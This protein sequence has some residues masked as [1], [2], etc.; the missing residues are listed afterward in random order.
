MDQE[1]FE[2]AFKS[3]FK[4]KGVK[5]PRG[6][7]SGIS[8][9]LN[10]QTIA[11]L[12]SSQVRYQWVA[13]AA[14]IVAIFSFAI[15]VN[16]SNGNEV[17]NVGGED[18][19]ALLTY[20]SDG[21]DLGITGVRDPF[22][23]TYLNNILFLRENKK[24]ALKSGSMPALIENEIEPEFSELLVLN[25]MKPGINQAAVTTTFNPYYTIHSNTILTKKIVK[26]GSSYWAGVEAGAGSFNPN[27]S[28]ADPINGDVDFAA[29]ASN[30]GQSGFVN[31]TSTASQSGM[32]P[33]VVTSFGVD[34]GVKLG[35][36]WTLESG[37]QYTNVQNQAFAALNVVDVYTIRSGNIFSSD[38]DLSSQLVSSAA[39]ETEV[40]EN[41]EHAVN[42]DHNMKF[43][44]IPVKAG[45][46]L[47][48]ERLSLRFNAG[49]S[50]NY[51]LSSRL[52]DPTGQM[53]NSESNG[54]NEWSFDGL[55]GFELGY[56]IFENFN[57]TLEPNYRQSITPLS[58]SL[59]N[60][61]GF[62]VQTGFRYIIR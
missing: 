27:F 34:F 36:K 13:A 30:I 57:L 32:D 5:P 62:M 25:K 20:N 2:S 7:W 1:S 50:A 18:F 24:I 17:T 3:Q 9:S 33:G 35:R 21:P 45:Y 61:S 22:F 6:V 23:N 29:L 10:D 54:Y 14:V 56:S 31:P 58:N 47:K 55:T 8:G 51:F 59:S 11:G 15:N 19:N 37:V 60:R 44:S 49:F 28:G 53:L 4:G 48:D 26:S 46:Y 39:G 12:Q 52:S 43:T 41:F 38:G 16:F 40:E 42:L